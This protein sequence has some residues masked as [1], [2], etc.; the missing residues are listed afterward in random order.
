MYNVQQYLY[1]DMDCSQII[2]IPCA[3][4]Y[5]YIYIN[6]TYIYIC[7]YIYIYMHRLDD[8]I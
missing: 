3:Y 5:I 6:I 7:I 2:L 4:V 1:N 8:I